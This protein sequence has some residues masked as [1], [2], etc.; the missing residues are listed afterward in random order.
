MPLFP[1]T[2]TTHCVINDPAL[3]NIHFSLLACL[4]S[5][6]NFGCFFVLPSLPCRHHHHHHHHQ[7]FFAV[8][9]MCHCTAACVFSPGRWGDGEMGGGDSEVLLG[10]EQQTRLKVFT[11]NN[12]EEELLSLL[13]IMFGKLTVCICCWI[14]PCNCRAEREASAHIQWFTGY[15]AHWGKSQR[16]TSSAGRW[17]FKESMKFFTTVQSSVSLCLP[18]LWWSML[19]SVLRVCFPHC[20]ITIKNKWAHMSTQTHTGTT[21]SP[22]V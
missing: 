5:Q 3:Q 21:P 7:P 6:E 11:D 19:G 17:T 4:P 16:A 12:T 15:P 14:F 22:V 9:V 20:H 8:H 13:W 18:V 1:T 2:F 10:E